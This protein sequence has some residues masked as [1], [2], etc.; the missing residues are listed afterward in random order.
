[1]IDDRHRAAIRNQAP[2]AGDLAREY[3]AQRLFFPALAQFQRLVRRTAD[4]SDLM[5]QDFHALLDAMDDSAPTL[6]AWDERI[7][8][9]NRR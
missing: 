8:G 9:S 3:Q 1:M 5:G 4:L 2:D 6:L 7:A